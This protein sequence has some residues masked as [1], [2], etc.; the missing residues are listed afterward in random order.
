MVELKLFEQQ[1]AFD[2]STVFDAGVFGDEMVEIR[3]KIAMA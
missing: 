3:G 2:N 1:A